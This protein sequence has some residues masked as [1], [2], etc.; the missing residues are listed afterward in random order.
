MHLKMGA[1]QTSS[2]FRSLVQ[3][4]QRILTTACYTFPFDL[5]IGTTPEKPP[6]NFLSLAVQA[7]R[8]RERLRQADIT[9]SL[10]PLA[11]TAHSL[12]SI[13]SDDDEDDEPHNIE[14]PFVFGDI[15]V[16]AWT[17]PDNHPLRTIIVADLKNGTRRLDIPTWVVDSFYCKMLDDN[18]TLRISTI[19]W[20]GYNDALTVHDYALSESDIRHVKHLLDTPIPASVSIGNSPITEGDFVFVPGGSSLLVANMRAYTGLHLKVDGIQVS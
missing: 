20:D 13:Y 11:H 2:A 19:C 9:K 17:D 3:S 12:P 8:L 6:P 16:Y 5:P 4:N 15:I 1:S 10:V 14:Y 7:V 18:S